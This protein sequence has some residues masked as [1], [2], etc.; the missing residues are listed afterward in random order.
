MPLFCITFQ[1]TFV[2]YPMLIYHKRIER[3]AK[4]DPHGF[5]IPKELVVLVGTACMGRALGM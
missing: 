2:E 1:M 5:T 4:Q 3:H